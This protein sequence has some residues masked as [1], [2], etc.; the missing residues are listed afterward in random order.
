MLTIDCDFPVELHR[1]PC[2]NSVFVKYSSGYVLSFEYDFLV[3]N[4]EMVANTPFIDA[5]ALPESKYIGLDV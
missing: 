2:N 1:S 3:T 4:L 5:L